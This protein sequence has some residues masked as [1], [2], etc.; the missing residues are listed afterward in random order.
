MNKLFQIGCVHCPTC[1]R[2]FTVQWWRKLFCIDRL[3]TPTSCMQV[4][5]LV[6][7]QGVGFP[8]ILRPGLIGAVYREGV[9]ILSVSTTGVPAR[10]HMH[11]D[12]HTVSKLTTFI[13][14][15]K[16][17]CHWVEGANSPPVLFTSL[18]CAYIDLCL[19]L[20]VWWHDLV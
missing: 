7:R 1:M 19:T 14:K 13:K 20:A 11:E 18:P 8:P 15:D 3:S 16:K 10:V 9:T 4:Y 6:E 2:P 17:H 12:M 5:F